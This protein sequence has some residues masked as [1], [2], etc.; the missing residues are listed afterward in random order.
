M[1]IVYLFG[2]VWLG[3]VHALCICWPK[4]A[5]TKAFHAHSITVSSDSYQ[6][7][8]VELQAWS[9]ERI[10]WINV[11][12]ML[13]QLITFG[14]VWLTFHNIYLLLSHNF[15]FLWLDYGLMILHLIHL[16]VWFICSVTDSLFCSSICYW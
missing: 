3:M 15:C 5:V 11:V 14:E 8:C 1:H 9:C 2:R 7:L 4:I 12:F 10:G 13:G 16:A 6:H